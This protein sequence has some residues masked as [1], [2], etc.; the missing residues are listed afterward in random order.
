MDAA[1]NKLR[2]SLSSTIDHLRDTRKDFVQLLEMLDREFPSCIHRE[3]CVIL[4]PTESTSIRSGHSDSTCK[5]ELES[6]LKRLSI[7]RNV[8]IDYK[9]H[10]ESTRIYVKSFIPLVRGYLDFIKTIGTK[11]PVLSTGVIERIKEALREIFDNIVRLYDEFEIHSDASINEEDKDFINKF[12]KEHN[13]SDIFV[14]EVCIP[15]LSALLMDEGFDSQYYEV[16]SHLWREILSIVESFNIAPGVI[17][18]L[19]ERLGNHFNDRLHEAYDRLS[20]AHDLY[21]REENELEHIIQDLRID[22]H[23][24]TVK[25]DNLYGENRELTT[26]LGSANNIIWDLSQQV[27]LIKEDKEFDEMNNTTKKEIDTL[28][29]ILYPDTHNKSNERMHQFKEAIDRY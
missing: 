10:P 22:V 13:P 4:D 5:I 26:K 28:K 24:L 19:I 9:Q 12:F 15:W 3:E 29:N 21:A 16:I 17:I 25:N 27:H 2:V 14:I 18:N 11:D 20:K 7:L 8:I 1:A 23:T 6:I